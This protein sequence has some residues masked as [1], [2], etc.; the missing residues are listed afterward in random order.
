MK[1]RIFTAAVLLYVTAFLQANPLAVIRPF[2][3]R[4]LLP[5]AAAVVT[6]LL[7]GPFES[8]LMGFLYGMS[9]D[10]LMGRTLGLHAVLYAAAAGLTSLVNEKLY[11]EKIFIQAA[12]SFVSVIVTEVLYYLAVFLL[13][14]YASFGTMFLAVILP[15][16]L[17]NSLLILPLFRPFSAI[18]ARLDVLDR[19]RIRLG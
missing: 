7:R 11:R 9:M 19:K 15:A 10:M 14:G 13:R 16:A 5:L 4:M 2:G 1:Y 18:Y 17:C 8:V 12:F 6:G 3:I